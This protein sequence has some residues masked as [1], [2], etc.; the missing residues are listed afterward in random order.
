MPYLN[1][2]QKR[3]QYY[4][5]YPAARFVLDG[6]WVL[7]RGDAVSGF[8]YEDEESAREGGRKLG[9]FLRAFDASRDS[10]EPDATPFDPPSVMEVFKS[11]P[12][13]PACRDCGFPSCMA[14]AAA[15]AREEAQPWDCPW[16]EEDG[17]TA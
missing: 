6:H 9:A 7:V 15:V 14:F 13:R 10:I 16:M 3:C 1:A 17:A 8:V 5:Q 11:L 4:P 2:T 12:R